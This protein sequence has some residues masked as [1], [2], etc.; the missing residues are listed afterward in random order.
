MPAKEK[1]L[2]ELN[3]VL[4]IKQSLY[5]FL[6]QKREDKNIQLASSEI[7]ESRI[8]DNGLD[9]NMRIP[10]PKI[11]YAIALGL[12]L[13]LPALVILVRVI[14][15]NKVETRKDVES[16]T[17]LVIAGEI[18]NVRKKSSEVVI[19]A[20]ATTPEAEQF[21]T[22]RTNISYLVQGLSQK[23]LMITSGKSAE[24]KSFI[25]LNLANSIAISGK[26]VALLE[27]DMRNP[28][29][30]KKMGLGETVGLSNYLLEEAD[31]QDI[32]QPTAAENL[33]F[34]SSGAPIPLNAGELILNNRMPALFKYLKQHFDV[35]VVDTPPV[36]PVSDALNLSKWADY[37]FFVIRHK[38]TFRSSLQLVNKLNAEQ[39]LPR[40]ALVI[41]GIQNNQDFNYGN[42]YGYGYGYQAERKKKRL[43]AGV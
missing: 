29:L 7:A 27:F 2:I 6:L 39:K 19:T 31:V 10:D 18:A 36:G 20:N 9:T 17:N 22:L 8:I 38:Y 4:E 42:D 35:V 40:L 34:L 25:S 26:K 37:T 1:Q 12:G 11:V 16:N 23:T 30:S 13:F 21:R 32:I 33:F 43:F 41:N 3:R 5:T 28:G 24:G 15:N 14:L